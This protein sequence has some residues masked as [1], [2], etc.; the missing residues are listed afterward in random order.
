MRATIALV[1]ALGAQ[2]AL[3]AA[4]APAACAADIA[5][6]AAEVAD[7][8]S[9]IAAAVKDCVGSD[10][11]ACVGDIGSTVTALGAA[12]A[13]ISKAVQDCGGPGSPCA[14]ALSQVVSALGS[15]T[16][17]VSKASKDCGGGSSA[18][19]AA[20]IL[21]AVAA[22]A[23]AGSDVAS[24]V[25]ACGNGTAR[26]LTNTADGPCC[27]TCTAP[28]SK[29]FS[30]VV[31]HGYC[32]ECCMDPK[33]YAL[34]KLFEKNL[35]RAVD[36]TPCADAFTVSGGHYTKYVQTVTHGMPG[37]FSMTLDLYSAP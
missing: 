32:G 37:V 25:A 17:A 1:F 10:H 11:A 6:A 2:S 14:T 15:A 19:C 12:S 36:N 18:A 3:A 24:A 8:G 23:S 5:E 27:K 20:D 21:G 31:S 16:A 33:K 26:M 30:V 9:K 13:D 35:T 29:F 34:Y 4:P 7:A 22:V 28:Q